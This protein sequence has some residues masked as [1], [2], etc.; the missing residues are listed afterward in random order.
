MLFAALLISLPG[1]LDRFP[2]RGYVSLLEHLVPQQAGLIITGAY[3]M[4][5]GIMHMLTGQWGH[6]GVWPCFLGLKWCCRYDFFNAPSLGL[7]TKPYN[8]CYC[9]TVEMYR[10][11]KEFKRLNQAA[12]ASST[13]TQGQTPQLSSLTHLLTWFLFFLWIHLPAPTGTRGYII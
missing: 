11:I 8:M 9:H 1:S 12:A 10:K 4:A 13:F 6:D 7:W 3:R 2:C 5:W